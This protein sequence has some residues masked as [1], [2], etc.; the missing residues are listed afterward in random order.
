[1]HEQRRSPASH[2]PAMLPFRALVLDDAGEI[3]LSVDLYVAVET[4]AFECA[5]RLGRGYDVEVWHRNR[6]L[7][8]VKAEPV[9]VV[10]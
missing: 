4:D 5:A 10:I 8:I 6:L 2:E 7:K 3:K 1:V 9:T